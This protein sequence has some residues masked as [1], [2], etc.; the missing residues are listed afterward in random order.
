[1]PLLNGIAAMA[2]LSNGSDQLG[3]DP[4]IDKQYAIVKQGENPPTVLAADDRQGCTKSASFSGTVGQTG[5]IQISID[6]QGTTVAG[7]QISTT[8]SS[9][10]SSGVTV[11]ASP[12]IAIQGNSKPLTITTRPATALGGFWVDSGNLQR[13]K[14]MDRK[15]SVKFNNAGASDVLKWLTKQNVNFVANTDTLPKSK[16][17][18]NLANVPLHEALDAVA[19]ALG[20]AWMV[21]GST[22]I[23]HTGGVRFSPFATTRNY[24]FPSEGF[25]TI[26]PRAFKMQPLDGRAFAYSFDEKAYKD[27]GKL[28][29]LDGKT[30]NYQFDDKAFKELKTFNEKDGVFARTNGTFGFK[31]VDAKKFLDSMSD[32]Q[33]DLMKK[34]GYLKV[35]DLT[36]DQKK[37]IFENPKGEL[38]K[39]FT[40]ML[41]LD[42]QKVTIKN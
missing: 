4:Q 16:I 33:K 20:G 22:L 17:T 25:R 36:E 39:Q 32:A 34:Q 29:G 12:G 21:K 41:N 10:A 18:V 42:G 7:G 13:L 24:T 1:M 11:I 3:V 6:Q 5:N 19:D 40:F 9:S 8:N 31:K 2:L 35:S 15:V 23:F 27:L 26:D 28:K 30:F 37:M 14:G 38:P